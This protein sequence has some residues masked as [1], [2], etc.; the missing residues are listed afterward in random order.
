M[1]T[2]A[3]TPPKR[4]KPANRAAAP[5]K[6][7]RTDKGRLPKQ[8]SA[9]LADFQRRV[10][11]LFPDDILQIILYGSYARGDA[12]PGSDVDV[13]VVVNWAD[14]KG[15]NAYYLPGA[16]DPRWGQVVDAATD[17]TIECGPLLSIFPISRPLF[18]TDLPIARAAQEEGIVLWQKA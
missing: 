7:A 3:I 11:E 1:V 2:H 16:S 14:P 17:A 9:A 15:E 18:N 5:K 6:R 10:L 12:G 8:V 4:R 13:M